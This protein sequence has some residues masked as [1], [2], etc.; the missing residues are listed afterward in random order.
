MSRIFLLYAM[1]CFVLETGWEHNAGR[2]K[3]GWQNACVYRDAKSSCSQHIGGGWRGLC[4]LW[5][6]GDTWCRA[7]T[8][9][10]KRFSRQLHCANG[11]V[12][13]RLICCSVWSGSPTLMLCGTEPSSADRCP[14]P[15]GWRRLRVLKGL[16]KWIYLNQTDHEVS[17]PSWPSSSNWHTSFTRLMM[18]IRWPWHWCLALVIVLLVNWPFCH[19]VFCHPALCPHTLET[20]LPRKID[21]MTVLSQKLGIFRIILYFKGGDM[22]PLSPPLGRPWLGGLQCHTGWLGWRWITVQIQVG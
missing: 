6:C 1:P 13:R 15:T 20:T 7:F 10:W 5:Q 12:V 9:H 19:P 3:A 4:A 16:L 22:S 18:I 2:Q 8:L 21:L 14:W 17:P 11:A